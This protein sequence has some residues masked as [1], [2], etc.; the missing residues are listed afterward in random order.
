MI[1]GV[2]PCWTQTRSFSYIQY[3]FGYAQLLPENNRHGKLNCPAL[4]G[5]KLEKAGQPVI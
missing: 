1:Q 2:K 3:T 4:P 5:M